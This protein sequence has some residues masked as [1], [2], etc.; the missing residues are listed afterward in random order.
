MW[1]RPPLLTD[2]H[3]LLDYLSPFWITRFLDRRQAFFAQRQVQS[4]QQAVQVMPIK[5]DKYI[6]ALDL[7]A[8]QH[9]AHAKS[10]ARYS[11]FVSASLCPNF[12]THEAPT[13]L[14]IL[15]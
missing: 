10:H 2:F 5:T 15:P 4:L 9:L 12:T 1:F 13:R 8:F 11:G 7:A 3:S 6:V 14:V